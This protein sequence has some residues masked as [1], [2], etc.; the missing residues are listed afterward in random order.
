MDIKEQILEEITFALKNVN[1]GLL[2]L[3]LSNRNNYPTEEDFL[4]ELKN[5]NVNYDIQLD[6]EETKFNRKFININGSFIEIKQIISISKDKKYNQNLERIEYVLTL[7][8]DIVGKSFYPI[9]NFIYLTEESI[10][11]DM[12]IILKKLKVFGIILI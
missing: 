4:N 9:F 5:F 12:E 2:S 7:N 11:K 3:I 10:N 1:E 8:K 6:E